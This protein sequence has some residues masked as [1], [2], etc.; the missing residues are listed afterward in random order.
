MC[1]WRISFL[2]FIGMIVVVSSTQS[3]QGDESRPNAVIL[4]ATELVETIPLADVEFNDKPARIHTQGLFATDDHYFVTGRLEGA[5]KRPLLIRFNRLNP[6]QYQVLDLSL[7][8]PKYRD[9]SLDHPGG[10]DFDGQHFWIPIARSRPQGPTVVVKVDP[11]SKQPMSEWKAEIAFESEDHVGAIATDN[12][13]G[14]IYGANWDT[15]KIHV[16]S[17]TGKLL[18]TIDRD[19]WVE[20]N[21]EWALAV[22]DWKVLGESQIIAGG[23]DKSRNRKPSESRAVVEIYDV[24][25]RKLIRQI[26]LPSIEGLSK[27]LTNEGMQLLGNDLI[28]LPED[29][30]AGARIFRFRMPESKNG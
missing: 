9:Q 29:I 11:A 17:V 27:P 8:Q 18:R 20:S 23:I 15:K 1:A 24:A 4:S 22:Q 10:F 25:E 7:T 28:L 5:D 19:V 21:A 26:R 14:E 30:G 12:I 2:L 3:A 16:W 13:R 6:K